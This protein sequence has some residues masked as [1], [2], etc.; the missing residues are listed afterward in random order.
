MAQEESKPSVTS[1]HLDYGEQ[2]QNGVDLSL[3][4]R[5]LRLTP[6][7]RLRRADGEARALLRLREKCP[8]KPKKVPLKKSPRS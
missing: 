1:S 8:K 6:R 5:N 2:D 7:E 3:I 4:R